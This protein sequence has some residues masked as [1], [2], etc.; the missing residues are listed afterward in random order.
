MSLAWGKIKVQNSKLGFQGM[1][2]AFAPSWNQKLVFEPSEVG[3]QLYQET[4]FAVLLR[5]TALQETE[6][7]T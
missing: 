5:H 2:I 4:Q 1:Q 6:L 3:D 7:I